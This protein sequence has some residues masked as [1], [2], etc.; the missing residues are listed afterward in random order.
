LRTLFQGLPCIVSIV[1][2]LLDAYG[3]CDW[4][5][6]DMGRYAC[7]P[8]TI[9]SEARQENFCSLKIRCHEILPDLGAPHT[10]YNEARQENF[11]SLKIRCHEIF[12]G[13]GAIRMLSAHHLGKARL[14]YIFKKYPYH[15]FCFWMVS[16]MGRYNLQQV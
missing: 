5:L 10:I 7:A 15:A 12:P 16:D 6:P 2:A 11:C 3:D 14:L 13:M 8:D 1:T 4:I 9:Y